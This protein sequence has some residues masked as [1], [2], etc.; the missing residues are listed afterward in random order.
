M[1]ES[2]LSA[3]FLIQILRISIPY[4]LPAMGATISERGGVV[5]IALEGTLL[6]SAFFTTLGTF[7]TQSPLFGIL[8]GIVAGVVVS[9][10]HCFITVY[11]RADQ[12]VSGIGINLLALGLT[13]FLCQ[14]IFN[15]SSNSARIVGIESWHL[16]DLSRFISNPFIP[17]TVLVLLCVHFVVYKTRLGLRLRAVGENPA[18]ADTLGIS[19][20]KIRSI[21]LLFCG[22][23]TGL[24]GAW[25]A[26]DQHSFTDGMS[27]GRGFIALAA[28]IIGRWTPAG[29]VLAAILFGFS[30]SLSIRLQ[31]SFGGVQFFQIFPYILTMIVLSGFI[32]KAVPP[33]ADGIAYEKE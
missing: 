29:A 17:G 12:I 31:G 2:L 11:I 26:L 18:A 21:A 6:I 14:I 1:S 24:G 28:M 25:L 16:D 32:K 8:C 3:A 10:L 30:E 33:A 20:A 15:S 5:N 27:A 22:A 13:K 4:A 23:L 7:Y 9:L 19:V